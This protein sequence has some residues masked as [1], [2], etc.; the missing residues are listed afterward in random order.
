SII[1]GMPLVWFARAL[2]VAVPGRVC[3]SDLCAALMA[4]KEEQFRTFFFGATEETG[5]RVRQR[6][7]TTASR[8]RVARACSPAFGT[9][10]SMSGPGTFDRINQVHP[11]LLIVAIGARKGVVWLA[12]NEHLISTPVICNLGATINFV[13]G[14]VKRAPAVFRRNGLEWLWRI[15]EE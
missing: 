4:E 3:G 2:G 14:S 1:D 6:L 15:K 13:A 7:E 8:L 5:R 12:R 10:S 11:D 9:I